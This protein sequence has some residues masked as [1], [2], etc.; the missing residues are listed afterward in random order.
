MEIS[1]AMSPVAQEVAVNKIQAGY[2]GLTK[3]LQKTVQGAQTEENVQQRM[4]I[5]E[6]TGK[7]KNID[8]KA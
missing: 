3:T 2:D 5:A 1:G 8:I 7:G 6:Q 4:E